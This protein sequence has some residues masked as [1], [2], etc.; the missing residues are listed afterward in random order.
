L[1]DCGPSAIGKVCYAV[2]VALHHHHH[3]GDA[4]PAYNISYMI[5]YIVYQNLEG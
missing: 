3:I 4:K 2:P 5:Q 1:Q